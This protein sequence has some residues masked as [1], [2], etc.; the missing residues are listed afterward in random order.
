MNLKQINTLIEKDI[1]DVDRAIF[2]QLD[3][4]VSLINEL[5]SHIINSG[6]KRIRPIVALLSALSIGYQGRLHIINA[7]M[8]ELIHTATLLH[9]DVIDESRLRRGKTAANIKFGNSSSVLVGDFIYTK[10]FQ[11]MVSI[12]SMKIISLISETINSIVEG[13]ILQLINCNNVNISEE[14]YMNVIYRKTAHLFEAAAQTSC[15][16]ANADPLQEKALK[17]YGFHIGVAFQLIDDIL[18]YNSNIEKTG[19]KIGNDLEEGKLTFPLLH[20]IQNSSLEQKKMIRIA[21]EQGSSDLMD[22]ILKIMSQYGSLEWTRKRAEYEINKAIQAL[23]VIPENPWSDAL[24]SL[25]NILVQR[26]Y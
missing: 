13:E 24:R 19:K 8:I 5:G 22:Q 23:R 12:G 16:I 4:S 10:V 20:A 3:S 26:T 14:N 18:D 1:K 2:N 21:I 11:M 9:D 15:I 6:G 7:A 17:I 25:A